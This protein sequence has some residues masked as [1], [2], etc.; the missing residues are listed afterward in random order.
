ML[1]DFFKTAV[2]GPVASK[3]FALAGSCERC[4]AAKAAG[5]QGCGGFGPGC[6]AAPGPENLTAVNRRAAR[7]PL[8]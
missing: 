6:L 2:V 5:T 3:P 1:W 8:D 4:A 7:S